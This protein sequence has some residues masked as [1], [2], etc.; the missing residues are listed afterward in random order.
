MNPI[1]IEPELDED[2]VI[3][4]LDEIYGEVD[5]C[6]M[7]YSSGQALKELD[8]IAFHQSKLDLENNMDIRWECGNCGEQF[9][10]EDEAED[11]CKLECG[12]CAVLFDPMLLEDGLCED[13]RKNK[14]SEDEI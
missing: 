13:C 12:G 6:G 1:E 7:K 11:C 10:T 14:E 3:E 2:E 8:P 9:E 5:I 4:Q